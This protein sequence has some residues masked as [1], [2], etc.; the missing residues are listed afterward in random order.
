MTVREEV[1]QRIERDALLAKLRKKIDSGNGTFDDS[2]AYSD[3]AGRLL[4]EIF[5]QR[6]PGIPLEEREAL[7]VE[8]LRDRYTD[9]NS[10]C[11][12]VQKALDQANGLHLKPQRAPFEEAR[13]HKIGHSTADQTVPEKTQQRRSRSATETMTRSMHDDRMQAEAKF[14][15][16][17]GLK[18]YITRKTDGKCCAWCS[19]M[20]GRYEYY[21]EPK[22]VY[23]RHDN[24]GCSVTY[25]NGRQRQDVWSKRTWEAPEPGAGAGDP[26]VFTAEQ[27][28][29][30]GAEQ[31]IRF[32]K[33]EKMAAVGA[34]VI[35]ADRIE[36][37]TEEKLALAQFARSLGIEYKNAMSFDGDSDLLKEQLSIMAALRDEFKLPRR[38][39]FYV[40]NLGEDL[41]ET[42]YRKTIMINSV[43]LRSDAAT[44]A[45]LN[46]DKKLSSSKTI[47][48]G[49]HEIGHLIAEKYGEIGLDIAQKACYN[50]SGSK[51]N[52]FQTLDYL[53]DNISEYSITKNPKA[54]SPKFKPT[55]F[56]EIIPEVLGKH[57][58]DPDE[59][60]T[61]FY[62]LLKEA[63]H[64]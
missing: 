30:A 25:E 27:A 47:G 23:R 12:A 21:S 8:L 19:A 41:G 5:A 57:F 13:A 16:R 48:I 11:D 9:I 22:D 1:R 40:K 24:C 26:V 31:P 29:S 62:K 7:C 17:A 52:Y 56:H 33:A 38:I 50:I 32:S 6:L 42:F 60:T 59:F 53:L 46:S 49:V 61:E 63:C 35:K 10:L 36:H 14:R 45:Y 15:S 64:I 37:S 55:H 34:D 18:C 39:V 51:L 44:S 2:F 4:G 28:R 54:T 3:R 43:A 20:A 58:T